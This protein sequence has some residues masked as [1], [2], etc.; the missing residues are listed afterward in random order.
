MAIHPRRFR[1]TRHAV[2]ATAL[3]GVIGLSGCASGGA[4]AQPPPPQAAAA[5]SA[6]V[7]S[8]GAKPTVVLVHGAFA[9][10]SSWDGVVTRLQK[11][12]YTVVAPALAMRG[13]A[14]DSAYL[15]SLLSQIKCPVVLVGHSYGGAVIS[16]AATGADS[17]R[18]LV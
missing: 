4:S 6:Q 17:V 5:P 10:A 1:R 18:A 16:N 2:T 8:E 15:A 11:Q 9:D 14:S 12:G 13:L 3:L 7:P